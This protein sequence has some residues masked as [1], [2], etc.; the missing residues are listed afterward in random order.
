MDGKKVKTLSETFK[1]DGSVLC[2]LYVGYAAERKVEDIRM[3]AEAVGFPGEIA[4]SRGKLR[5]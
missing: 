3:E 4:T 5:S 2:F 1:Q